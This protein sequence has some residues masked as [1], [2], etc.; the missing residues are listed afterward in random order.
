MAPLDTLK[1]FK[2]LLKLILEHKHVNRLSIIVPISY[3]ETAFDEHIT[4][5]LN[6]LKYSHGETIFKYIL[7]LVEP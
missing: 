1:D 2:M 5:F 6:V 3:E 4:K 7:V